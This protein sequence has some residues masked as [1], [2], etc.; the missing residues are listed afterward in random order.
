MVFLAKQGVIE[1]QV[2]EEL[3]ISNINCL[4]FLGESII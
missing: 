1:S 3:L 2:K 4:I